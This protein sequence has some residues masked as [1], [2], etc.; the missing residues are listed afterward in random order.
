M[1]IKYY[2]SRVYKGKVPAIDRVMAKK[3]PTLTTGAQNVASSAL[4][5]IISSNDNWQV[6]SVAFTF[7]NTNSRN[8]DAYIR[9]GRKIV[10]NLNDYLWIQLGTTPPQTI[11]L[12][13]GFYNGTQLAAELKSKLDAQ[14]VFA[15]H[16]ITFTVTYDAATGYFII[17]PSSG[18]IRYLNNNASQIMTIRDSIAGHLFGL[19]T[20]TALAA[21]VTSDT[22]VFGL[23]SEVAFIHQTSSVATSYLHTDV[24][25]LSIDQAV[26]LTSNAGSDVTITYSIVHEDII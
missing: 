6:D 15:A 24:H 8:F 19:N 21:N 17:T 14:T 22:A 13:P 7:S 1:A 2:P 3:S 5:A 16:S 23:D 25:P 4:S 18:T 9:N 26:H 11:T 12:S 20:T 10:E